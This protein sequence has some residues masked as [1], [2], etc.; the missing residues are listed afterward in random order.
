MII[1]A[2]F[3]GLCVC[4][5]GWL[6]CVLGGLGACVCVFGGGGERAVVCER[7]SVCVR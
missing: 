2:W 1:I 4:L 5:V 6:G 7:V 3:C